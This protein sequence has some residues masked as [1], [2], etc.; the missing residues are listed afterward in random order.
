MRTSSARAVRAVAVAAALGLAVTG[1]GTSSGVSGGGWEDTGTLTYWMWDSAQ[2]PA[3]QQCAEQFEA[4]NPDVDVVIEQFGWDDYWDK[5]FTAFVSDSA[6]DV[7]VDH[8]S[9]YAD[10]ATRGL[11]QPLDELVERDGVDLDAYVEGT[12][13]LWV[14]PDGQRYGLP[15]DFDTVGVFYNTAMVEEAGYTRE[16][17]WSLD[18]NPQDGG[19]YEQLVARLT[20]DTNGVRGDEPGFDPTSVATYGLALE[21]AGEGFGQTE[22]SMYTGANG[23]THTDQPLW[24]TRYAYDEEAFQETVAWWRGLVEKGYMP[25]LERTVGGS[26]DQQLQADRYA[27]ATQGSW[28]INNLTRL[29]GIDLDV[30]PTPVGPTG[31]R[32]AMFNSLADSIATSSPR[33]GAAWAWVQHLASVECQE[34]VARGGVV[35]PARQEVVPIAEEALS[36]KGIDIE[37]FTVHVEEG[38]T[39]PVPITE[40]YSEVDAIM[41]PAMDRVMGFSAPV[42]SL[43]EANRRVNRLFGTAGEG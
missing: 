32:A 3:Y 19:S 17:L 24:G 6:P 42:E 21:G 20:V 26:V 35:L 9:R 18:W 4:A 36:A 27:M 2:L 23:W 10:Y 13:D 43:T 1:C 14:G 40:N 31:E 12:T 25:P 16:D 39:I 38:T 29:E 15:K 8:T 11:L 37:A 28:N 7:F 41:R 30:F 33:K 22:W 34:V 5:L